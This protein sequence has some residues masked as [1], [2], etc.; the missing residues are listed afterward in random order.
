MAR[1]L[2][3][4]IVYGGRSGEHEV[5]VAS[6]RSIMGAI[7]ATKYDLVPIA[8]A[9]NGQWPVSYTHLSCRRRG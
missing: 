4:G 5:S 2:R 9:R 6:T 3:I 7:D 1:K 8:I